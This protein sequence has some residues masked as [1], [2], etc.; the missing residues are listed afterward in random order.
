MKE[1]KEE[2]INAVLINC[3]GLDRKFQPGPGLLDRLIH[4]HVAL[5]KI[6]GGLLGFSGTAVGSYRRSQVLR[7][8]SG[9]PG[10]FSTCLPSAVELR[11]FRL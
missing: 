7:S 8:P 1:L 2:G 9:S 10:R 4:K 11:S 5:V 3:R 6:T